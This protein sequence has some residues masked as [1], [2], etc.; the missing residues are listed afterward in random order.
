MTVRSLNPSQFRAGL[1][2][3]FLKLLSDCLS[4][5]VSPPPPRSLVS[6]TTQFT[7]SSHCLTLLCPH[8]LDESTLATPPCP[9]TP[10]KFMRRGLGCRRCSGS[11]PRLS[12]FPCRFQRWNVPY[13]GRGCLETGDSLSRSILRG[14]FLHTQTSSS[15]SRVAHV[16][17]LTGASLSHC[18]PA[19]LN[20]RP[21]LLCRGAGE[22]DCFSF[23]P[24]SRVTFGQCCI[25]SCFR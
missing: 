20:S 22:S 6:T 25:Y 4:S 12:P 1:R 5:A 18:V 16:A 17:L 8:I 9:V 10:M 13:R 21:A 23:S 3:V 2:W 15:M 11:C 7:S 24:S 14:T 19:L